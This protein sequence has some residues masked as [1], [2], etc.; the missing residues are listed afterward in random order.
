[1][2]PDY[3]APAQ[4]AIVFAVS[5]WDVNCQQHIAVRHDEDTIAKAMEKAMCNV[6]QENGQLKERVRELEAAL[7]ASQ[8]GV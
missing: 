4:R 5:A 3:A 2:V 8:S 6:M 7:A 1:M